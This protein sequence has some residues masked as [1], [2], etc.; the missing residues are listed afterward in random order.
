M[1]FTGTSGFMLLGGK[2]NFFFTDFRYKGFAEKPEYVVFNGHTEALTGAGFT[3]KNP[4]AKGSCG[5]GSS[6]DA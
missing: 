5:C 1:G 3:I 4:N 6:F 2:K